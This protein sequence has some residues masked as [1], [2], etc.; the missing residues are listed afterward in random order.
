MPMPT[1]TSVLFLYAETPLHVGAGS[2]LGAID[3]PLQRERVSGHPIV[4][5]S[6]LKG[7]LREA[8]DPGEGNAEARRTFHAI[9]GPPPPEAPKGDGEEGKTQEEAFASALAVGDARLILFPM[10]SARGAWAWLTCPAVID[11]LRRTLTAAGFG[12]EVLPPA[13]TVDD[14]DT[15]DPTIRVGQASAIVLTG[16]FSGTPQ[17]AVVVEDLHYAAVPSPEVEALA[18]WL[19]ANALPSG[20][21]NEAWAPF[22]TR[23]PRQLGVVSDTE[24]SHLVQQYTEVA[25]RVRMDEKRGTVAKGGLWTEEALPAESLLCS[26]LEFDRS[27]DPKLNLEPTKAQETFATYAKALPRTW[28]GGD[29]TTGRGLM[30]LTHR[31]ILKT[32][33]TPA[34][35]KGAPQPGVGR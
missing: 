7:A 26:C 21:E 27:H 14:T 16:D 9:F 8:M 24:F 30:T 25:T 23:L 15:G 11:R 10:R 35:Q 1:A 3:L 17:R 19:V 22:R 20:P 2:G 31:A 34:P 33:S 29:R 6:G 5:G 13:I 12:K 28:I 32:A 18:D 4:P